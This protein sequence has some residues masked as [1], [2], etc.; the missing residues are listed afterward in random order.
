MMC[1]REGQIT[2]EMRNGR[3]YRDLDHFLRLSLAHSFRSCGAVK[4]RVTEDAATPL[5]LR[6]FHKGFVKETAL[7]SVPMT[8]TLISAYLMSGKVIV[9]KRAANMDQNIIM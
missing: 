1:I 4:D 7:T 3:I 5:P 6:Y 2:A 9:G 8:K